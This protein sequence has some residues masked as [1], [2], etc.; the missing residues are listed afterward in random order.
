M[1]HYGMVDM[2]ILDMDDGSIP[3]RGYMMMV[4]RYMFYYC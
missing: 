2:H 3:P 4:R 1:S